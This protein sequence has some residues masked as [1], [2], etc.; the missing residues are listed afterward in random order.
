MTISAFISTKQSFFGHFCQ[1]AVLGAF[2]NF[3]N[4]YPDF[5]VFK[6]F[7]FA[8]ISFI[9]LNSINL[10]CLFLKLLFSVC[11]V[12]N[13]GLICSAKDCLNCGL[14]Q[15]YTT[16][17]SDLPAFTEIIELLWCSLLPII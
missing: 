9:S 1:F 10:L 16:S 3:L 6:D 4:F 15:K 12:Q 8:V 7:V 14:L 17:I 13:S 5:S 2:L 11:F